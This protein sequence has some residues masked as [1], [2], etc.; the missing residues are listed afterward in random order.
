[1][2]LRIPIILGT[3][4]AGRKSEHVAIFAQEQAAAFG[5]TSEL[6]DVREFA[7]STTTTDDTD[8]SV[9]LWRKI[10]TEAD[11][12]I[13]VVPEYNHGY[14][15]ELKIL[16][17]KAFEEYAKKPAGLVAVSAG[18]LGGARVVEHIISVFNAL[19]LVVPKQHVY[20]SAVGQMFPDGSITEEQREGMT[21]RLQSLF[22]EIKAYAEALKPLQ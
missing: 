9:Q 22:T 10:V 1:M 5:F 19:Q 16:L 4:R 7:T 15:G 3:G 13:F 2:P 21:N 8:N 11:G 6:I 18:G 12:F 14:P 20:V 17:D